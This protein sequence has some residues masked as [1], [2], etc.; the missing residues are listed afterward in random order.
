M[1]ASTLAALSLSS[2]FTKIGALVAFA[3]LIGIAFLS[4][5]LFSQA[6]ELKRLREWADGDD[7]RRAELERRVST[8][9]AARLQRLQKARPP[10]RPVPQAAAAASAVVAS[11]VAAVPVENGASPPAEQPP[12]HAEAPETPDTATPVA[13]PTS[14]VE[15][16]PVPA[17]PV[18][19]QDAP[20]AGLPP[21]MT[22]AGLAAAGLPQASPPPA[23]A[24]QEAGAAAPPSDAQSPGEAAVD[25][26]RDPGR[27]PEIE[28]SDRRVAAA[29]SEA[30]PERGEPE[31]VGVA[32]TAGASLL[33]SAAVDLEESAAPVT[34]AARGTRPPLPPAPRQAGP[35]KAATPPTRARISAQRAGGT[36]ADAPARS[37]PPGPPFLEEDRP[38]RPTRTLIAIGAL[39]GVVVLVIAVL[40]LNGEHPNNSA[41]SSSGTTSGTS[42][43][44]TGSGEASAASPATTAVVVLNG[45][46]AQGLAHRLSGDLQQSGYTQAKAL[47][48]H[49]PG[50][51]A[52]TVVEYSSGHRADAE[53]VAQTLGIAKV[54]P[55]DA[56]TAALVGGAS[57]AVVAGSDQAALSG[58]SS[59]AT[60]TGAAGAA[61]AASPSGA[62]SPAGGAAGTEKASGGEPASG[63]GAASGGAAEPGGAGEP[64]TG[65]P[66]G[67]GQG[68]PDR[69]LP[70]PSGAFGQAA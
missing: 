46:E 33:A 52:T 45:T 7:E 10:A 60:T 28:A 65:E 58:S 51:H 12:E 9:T 63:G 30:P 27:G 29:A 64:A 50:T 13:T 2:T 59:G 44:K 66:A 18:S 61:G 23:A 1:T 15:V 22:P 54:Q 69:E 49:P 25:P 34:A 20:A 39:V 17:A 26:E 3:A 57:V 4:L 11:R 53:H 5:L 41:S 42:S 55:L 31:P 68:G 47:D 67:A 56:G 70:G 36:A 16:P 48:G 40:S 19:A 6:R 35:A 32:A 24:A 38:R 43:T 37:R 14:G 62:A 8:E 21:A